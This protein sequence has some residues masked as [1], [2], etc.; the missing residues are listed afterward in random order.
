MIANQVAGLN[1]IVGQWDAGEG[2]DDLSAIPVT[3]NVPYA[4][5]QSI[6]S[7]NCTGCHRANTQNSG[8][9]DL[10]EGNSLAA[11]LNQPSN[12]VPGLTLV[13]P[14]SPSRSYLFEKVNRATPQQGAR[15]RPSD[16]MTL[17]N[18]AL[19]RDWIAQLSSTYESFLLHNYL[20]TPSDPGSAP[21]EDFD[22]DG[23][24]NISNYLNSYLQAP[25]VEANQVT[26]PLDSGGNHPTDLNL[27]IEES[28]DLS[29]WNPFATRIRGGVGWYLTD[30][31]TVDETD[32]Q[33]ILLQDSAVP[34]HSFYRLTFDHIGEASP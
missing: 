27:I 6:F 13:K 8:G 4:T 17:S 1:I 10:T 34:S 22:N 21:A 5:I 16:S 31:L 11:L 12:F 2:R 20:A 9:L 19:I 28:A 32:P 18:Q 25:L 30:S 33:R 7:N 3:S 14:G 15:M 24:S 26:L 29:S 23:I